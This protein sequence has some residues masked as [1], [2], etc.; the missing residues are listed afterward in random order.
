MTTAVGV[1]SPWLFTVPYMTIAEFKAA[2]TAVD[3]TNLYRGGNTAQQ[4]A[5][6]ANVVNRASAW[7]NT[8]CGQNL[9][10][11]KDTETGRVVVNRAGEIIVHPRYWPTLEVTDFQMGALPS[12]L[13]ALSDFSNVFIE[14]EKFTIAS[15]ALTLTSSAGPLQFGMSPAGYRAYARWTYVNGWPVTTVKTAAVHAAPTLGVVDATGCYPGTVLTIADADNTET[16]TVASVAGTTLTL[17]ANLA[18]DHAIGIGIS[19]L[20]PSVKEACIALTSAFVKARGNGAIVMA[21]INTPPGQRQSPDPVQGDVDIAKQL[22]RPFHT[23][24]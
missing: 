18:H 20:P 12:E 8:I 11:T 5:E 21:Q 17:T 24:R 13:S 14:R 7:V 19:S 9:A 4:D 22:L 16:V 3:V 15:T 6:L 23:I 1:Q 2:P 10:A